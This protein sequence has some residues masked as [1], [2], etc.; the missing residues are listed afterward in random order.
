MGGTTTGQVCL[1][2]V[3]KEDTHGRSQSVAV[4]KPLLGKVHECNTDNSL[5]DK[6]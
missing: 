5:Y 2:G 1:R 4:A 3:R 6:N